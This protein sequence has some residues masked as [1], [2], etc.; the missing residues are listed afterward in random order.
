MRKALT[1]DDGVGLKC[2]MWDDN[3]IANRLKQIEELEEKFPDL[4]DSS[5]SEPGDV[6]DEIVEEDDEPEDIS[7]QELMD[8]LAHES[9]GCRKRL[10]CRKVAEETEKSVENCEP[11]CSKRS[12]KR[13]NRFMRKQ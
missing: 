7:I 12:R 2:K 8:I 13:R 1:N 4:V 9:R 10:K 6:N 5:D 3:R 11:A